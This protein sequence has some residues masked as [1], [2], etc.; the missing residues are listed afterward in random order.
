MI[1]PQP[2]VKRFGDR[3]RELLGKLFRSLGSDNVHEAEAFR[4]RIDSLL[5]TFNKTWDDL[6]GLLGAGSSIVLDRDVIFDIAMLGHANPG[7]RDKARRRIADRLALH[8]KNWNDL[9]DALY[10]VAPAPWLGPGAT[11][12]PVRVNPLNLVIH[13]LEEY[14]DLRGPHEYIAVALWALHTHTYDR[15]MITP[16]MALRSPVA[17]CGKT[18][19]IDVLTKLTA[20]P[21]KFDSIT[22]AAIFR[23]IDESHP[24]LF[25]DEAD[26]LGIALG[27]N[28]RL[29]AVFNSGHRHGG[30]V[31]LME[32]GEVREFST[33]APLLLALPD[34]VH[35]L[36]RTL[37]SRCITL[38]MSRSSGRRKLKSFEPNRPDPALDAAY[39][40][41]LL[42]RNDVVFEPNPEMPKDIHNRL[43][44][45]W[46]PLLSIADSL[47]RG[48]D[49]RAALAI[50]ARDFTDADARI[51]LLADIRRVFDAR[52]V[53]RL[54][55]ALLLDALHGFDDADWSEFR[56]IRADQSP[57]KLKVGELA[58]M[59]RD[60]GIRSR[61]IWP[62]N[63]TNESRSAK[64]Y[65]RQQFEE[66]WRTYCSEDGTTA[67]PNNVKGL[68][69]AAAGTRAGTK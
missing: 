50:F 30:Q 6:I 61:S 22:T 9:S 66:V 51:L 1:K 62:L 25:I 41:V 42:W 20:R 49:A 12:D 23:M 3:E 13:L 65:S 54:P 18:Q 57:H 53:D 4:G 45:N 32:A 64:G 48:D 39:K 24:T 38:I 47:G 10:G 37:N 43:A 21:A 34:A 35:G 67:Q 17:G 55:S 52:G 36:P 33:F 7:A 68:H 19:L 63:R 46:R 26:N 5:N 56:G 69:V 60:F 44:D 59:L 2:I 14:V 40:Q 27:T 29:R 31:G 15:F 16:R 8:R 11:P 28:G 58:G